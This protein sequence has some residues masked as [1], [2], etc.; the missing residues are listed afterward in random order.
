MAINWINLLL[1]PFPYHLPYVSLLPP[2][3]LLIFLIYLLLPPFHKAMLFPPAPD[4]YKRSYAI[5]ALTEPSLSDSPTNIVPPSPSPSPLNILKSGTSLVGTWFAPSSPQPTRPPSRNSSAHSLPTLSTITPSISYLITLT[6]DTSLYRHTPLTQPS[7]F[8]PL[9]SLL[10]FTN[11]VDHYALIGGVI[12][13]T[14]RT[15]N[16]NVVI[17]CDRVTSTISYR[18]AKE[19]S[20]WRFRKLGRWECNKPSVVSGALLARVLLR[21]TANPRNSPTNRATRSRKRELRPARSARISLSLSRSIQSRVSPF[22][23]PSRSDFA[24]VCDQESEREP[25]RG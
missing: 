17:W 2:T 22:P 14:T 3:L 9:A 12:K 24:H 5:D 10:S 7:P 4:R 6:T 16:G 20:D 18:P 25:V 13:L 15:T 8:L 21:T 23:N 11:T 19:M 1:P